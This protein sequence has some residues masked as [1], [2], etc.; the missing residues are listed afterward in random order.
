MAINACTD[1]DANVI[2]SVATQR[3]TDD[4]SPAIINRPFVVH[5]PGPQRGTSINRLFV[6]SLAGLLKSEQRVPAR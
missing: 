4:L 6:D 2:L 5:Q 1:S 3:T